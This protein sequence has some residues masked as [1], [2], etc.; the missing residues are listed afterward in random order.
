MLSDAEK[1]RYKCHIMI[2]EIGETGQEKLKA[3]KVLVI[4]AGGLGAPVLQY[5]TAAGVGTIAIMDDDVVNEDNLHRQILYGGHDLG[6]LKT[7]ISKQRLNSLNPLVNHEIYN[8][9]LKP[10]NALDFITRYDIVV[11]TADNTSTS[12]LINDACII[13]GKP[14]VYGS[15][16]KFEG[17]VSTFNCHN[18]P[19]LRC[20]FPDSNGINAYHPSHT[21]VFG[22]LPGIIGSLQAIEVIKIITG[23]GIP[24]FGKMLVYNMLTHVIKTVLFEK[25][26]DNFKISKLQKSY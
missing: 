3:A 14:W 7:I 4:G 9:H 2:P 20:V 17:Q 24:L 13:I 12:Y 25:N 19:S 8:I 10:E 18:S 22:V 26:F 1:R 15:L 5:L 11:D 23:I 21:G 16:Q 6:K